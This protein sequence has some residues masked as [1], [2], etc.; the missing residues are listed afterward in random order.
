MPQAPTASDTATETA[1][2]LQTARRP[3]LTLRLLYSGDAGV[4]VRPGE[5][6]SPGALS[7]GRVVEPGLSLPADR[8]AS[9]HHATITVNADETAVTVRDQGSKNGT[10]VNGERITEAPLRD[11]DLLRIGDSFFLLR[12]E[13]VDSA[14]DTPLDGVVGIS[15]AMRALRRELRLLSPTRTTVLLL[16]ETGTGKEV[17]AQALHRLSERREQPLVVLDGGAVPRTLIEAELFGHEAGAFT[18][19]QRSR[20]GLLEQASGGTLFIDEL[21]ELPLDLQ[22][23]L[24]R[25]IEHGTIRRVGSTTALRVDVRII[26]ATN[27]DLQREVQSKHFR[28]DLYARLAEIS[29]RLP[30]LRERREDVLPLLLHALGSP[31]PRLSPELVEALLLHP[32]PFNVR[33]VM[34]IAAELRTRGQGAAVFDIELIAHRLSRPAA[35]GSVPAPTPRSGPVEVRSR[36]EPATR[37][38]QPSREELQRLLQTATGGVS[39]VARHLGCSRKQIYRWMDLHG[40][41]SERPTG[42]GDPAAD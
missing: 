39:E 1:R 37:L 42:D 33:E 2:T 18:G 36:P 29:L 20:Q 11:G 22:P 32:F 14:V 35:A 12:H 16:G 9:R 25:A 17:C 19:A 27:R 23:M 28:A 15:P 8:R 30:P 26:A 34:K 6:L 41:R 31:T 5:L 4:S 3:L 40:L 21:G 10:F 7:I 24:L 13:P 38:T